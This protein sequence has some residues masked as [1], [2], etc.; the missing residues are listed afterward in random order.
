MT[1]YVLHFD[2]P[3]KH[4]KHYIGFTECIDNRF[5]RHCNGG[6]SPLVKAALA[7]GCVVSVAHVF[8]GA[9]R[10]FERKLKNRK[11]TPRWCRL[12][13]GERKV[14]VPVWEES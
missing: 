13:D 5:E 8:E 1:V 9:D 7:A 14:K 2:P 11:D 10:E 4:A 6:G 12:C 3:Y